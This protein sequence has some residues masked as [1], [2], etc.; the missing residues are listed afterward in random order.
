MNRIDFRRLVDEK[1]LAIAL[2]VLSFLPFE[3]SCIP[4][5]RFIIFA[6]FVFAGIRYGVNRKLKR[7][8]IFITLG[9]LVLV[10]FMALLA[11]LTDCRQGYSFEDIIQPEWQR[12]NI[13]SLGPDGK[14]YIK[15]VKSLQ[16]ATTDIIF[17][18]NDTQVPCPWEGSARYIAPGDVKYCQLPTECGNRTIRVEVFA[19]GNS[20]LI[21]C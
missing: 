8:D 4:G 14:L 13:D 18:V 3:P 19:P 6:P 17:H 7:I 16:I 15:N 11:G 12:I 5:N 1:L 2:L 21:M 9:F 20:D 10:I